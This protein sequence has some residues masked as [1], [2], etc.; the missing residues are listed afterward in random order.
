MDEF[1]VERLTKRGKYEDSAGL[2]YFGNEKFRK[3][4]YFGK[5]KLVANEKRMTA[6]RRRAEIEARTDRGIKYDDAGACPRASRILQNIKSCGLSVQRFHE[7]PSPT[8][9]GLRRRRRRGARRESSKTRRVSV[10]VLRTTTLTRVT[11]KKCDSCSTNY[12]VPLC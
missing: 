1:M 5:Q 12:Y 9:A 8:A 3:K 7:S 11:L 10:V 6:K 2:R 4:N